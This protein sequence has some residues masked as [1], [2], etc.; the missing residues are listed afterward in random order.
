MPEAC[1]PAILSRFE[2]FEKVIRDTKKYVKD[3]MEKGIEV[4]GYYLKPGA[5]QRT[6]DP[7][8]IPLLYGALVKKYGCKESAFM[9]AS[10]IST[11]AVKNIIKDGMEPGTPA[12]VIEL[13]LNE[14]VKEFGATKQN[15]ASLKPLPKKKES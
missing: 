15:A 7:E 1:I 9:E 3:Q 13:K 11:Q 10:S 8:K 5:V 6:F 4:E 2:L 12:Q 14:L